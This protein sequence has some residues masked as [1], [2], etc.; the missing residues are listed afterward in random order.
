MAH[1]SIDKL[2]RAQAPA[3]LQGPSARPCAMPEAIFGEPIE[4][5]SRSASRGTHGSGRHTGRIRRLRFHRAPLDAMRPGAVL[6]IRVPLL[7]GTCRLLAT[8]VVG[9]IREGRVLRGRILEDP[10]ARPSTLTLGPDRVYGTLVTP[11][12][13]LELEARGDVAWVFVTP[14]TGSR[15]V[16]RAW[17]LPRNSSQAT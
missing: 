17:L 8:D 15:Q 5:D 7:G 9:S 10:Q 13:T 12:G 3:L 4:D 11:R 6:V 2:L 14:N 16:Q 1:S